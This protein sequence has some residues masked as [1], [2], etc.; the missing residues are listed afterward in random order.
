MPYQE[1]I[2]EVNKNKVIK[3]FFSILLKKR[4]DVAKKDLRFFG[5][6]WIYMPKIIVTINFYS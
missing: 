5:T 4:L 6:K 1:S 3:F 2:T